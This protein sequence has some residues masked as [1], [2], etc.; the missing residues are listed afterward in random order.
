MY[1]PGVT[2]Q[3]QSEDHP[4][5]VAES[6]TPSPTPAVDPRDAAPVGEGYQGPPWLY[7][8][9][10]PTIDDD[11]P[12]RGRRVSPLAVLIALVALST[13]GWLGWHTW[14]GSMVSPAW[15]SDI[16]EAL[17][18]SQQ[19]GRPILLVV[20]ADWCPTCQVLEDSTLD[21]AQVRQVLRDG[22]VPVRLNVTN[23]RSDSASRA[24]ELDV[25]AVP[26][27]ILYGPDGGEIARR[28][29]APGPGELLAWLGEHAGR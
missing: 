3:P 15:A 1:L 9:G 26:T 27:L 11:P 25:S 12:G 18:L 5:G 6:S 2:D 22:W 16:G 7:P 10:A 13:V 29:G 14:S 24:V 8:A 4:G 20:T 17:D 23:P 28:P 19:Q 21:D